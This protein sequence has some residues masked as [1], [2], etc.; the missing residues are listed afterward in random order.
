MSVP[1]YIFLLV[2]TLVVLILLLFSIATIYHVTRYA[3][4]TS[5]SIM[6]TGFFVAGFVVMLGVSVAFIFQIDWLQTVQ[7]TLLS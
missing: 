3:L 1:L 6:V 2:Y 4:K 7:F 5:V